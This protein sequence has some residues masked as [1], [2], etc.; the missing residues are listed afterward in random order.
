MSLVAIKEHVKA[1]IDGTTSEH[2]PAAQARITPLPD[3]DAAAA[4]QLFIATPGY[5]ERRDS[6][7]RTGSTNGGIKKATHQVLITCLAV[8]ANDDPNNDIAFDSL[9]EAVM[10]QLRKDTVPIT[11]TDPDTNGTSQLVTIGEEFEVTID[12]VRALSNQRLFRWLAE[13]RMPV[14]EA[15]FA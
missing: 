5:K 12:I 14:T 6:G 15:F 13:I 1:V 4:P 11:I 3:G 2:Y 8:Y 10:T 7:P 9:L